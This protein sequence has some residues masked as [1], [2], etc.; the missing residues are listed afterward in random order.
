MGD[1]SQ[2]IRLGL[3]T[4]VPEEATRAQAALA[5]LEKAIQGIATRA[6]MGAISDKEALKQIG[7][8]EAAYRAET[9]AVEKATETHVTTTAARS[10]LE[11]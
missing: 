8:M 2:Q 1:I 6:A 5:A 3:K 10:T 7:A 11:P 9:A 4:D